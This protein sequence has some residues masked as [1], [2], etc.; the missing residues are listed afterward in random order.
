MKRY[1]QGFSKFDL[2]EQ[3]KEGFWVKYSNYKEELSA[4]EK[5]LSRSKNYISS[6]LEKY[7]AAKYFYHERIIILFVLLACSLVFNLL[8]AMAR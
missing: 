6:L 2:M 1:N 8:F 7:F 5:Q 3:C 4:K